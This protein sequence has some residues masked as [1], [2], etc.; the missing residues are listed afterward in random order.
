MVGTKHSCVAPQLGRCFQ[1][2]HCRKPNDDQNCNRGKALIRSSSFG[3]VTGQKMGVSHIS[4]GKS[5]ALCFLSDTRC[6]GDSLSIAFLQ[7]TSWS[8]FFS[9]AVAPLSL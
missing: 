4:F 3:S 1:T 9:D 7:R 2:D 6:S 5:L 8:E